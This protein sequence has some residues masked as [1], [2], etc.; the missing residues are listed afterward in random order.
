MKRRYIF[1]DIEQAHA[2]PLHSFIAKEQ[3]CFQQKR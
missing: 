2:S 1:N 3:L